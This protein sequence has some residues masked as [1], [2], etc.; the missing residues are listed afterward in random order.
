M[1]YSCAATAA[2]KGATLLS[3]PTSRSTPHPTANPTTCL[4]FQPSRLCFLGDF[5]RP[6]LLSKN[7]GV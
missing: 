1:L 2:H 4:G 3:P 5:A 6:Y 7:I